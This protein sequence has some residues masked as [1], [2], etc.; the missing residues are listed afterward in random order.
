MPIE[1]HSSLWLRYYLIPRILIWVEA[2]S[3]FVIHLLYFLL[4]SGLL[5]SYN[6]QMIKK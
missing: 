4:R 3:Q 5:N 1:K 6:L 2:Q